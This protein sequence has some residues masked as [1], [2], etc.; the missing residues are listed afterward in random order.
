[1]PRKKGGWLDCAERPMHSD[2][3]IA[4]PSSTAVKAHHKETFSRLLT[5]DHGIP[6]K[7]CT[8]PRVPRGTVMD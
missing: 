2:S 6:Q 4:T 1:M 8:L 3:V 7:H 5:P